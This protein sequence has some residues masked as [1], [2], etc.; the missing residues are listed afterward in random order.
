MQLESLSCNN[1][2]APVDVPQSANFITCA[3][4]GSRLAVKRTETAHYTEVLDRLQAHA[5]KVD[6]DLQYLR[7]QNDLMLLDQAWE[8]ERKQ[9]MVS[10]KYGVHEEPSLGLVIGSAI[11]AVIFT[12]VGGGMVCAITSASRNTG[13]FSGSGVGLF[14]SVAILMIVFVIA[15]TLLWCIYAYTKYSTY[16]SAEANYI[17]RRNDI[18]SHLHQLQGHSN[19]PGPRP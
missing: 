2:G 17:A 12:V 8:E 11:G 1:C 7:L 4:C 18:M 14:T 19:M 10:T 3:H 9:Y 13:S 6:R 15:A 16:K 5:H